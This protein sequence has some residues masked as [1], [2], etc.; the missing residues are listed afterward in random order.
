MPGED[1]KDVVTID[2]NR[3]MEET[4]KD[5]LDRIEAMLNREGRSTEKLCAKQG[6]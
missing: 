3:P 4:E 2:V 1:E 6:D 5:I